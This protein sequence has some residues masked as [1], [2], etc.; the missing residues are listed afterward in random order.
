MLASFPNRGW[1]SVEGKARTLGLK[2]PPKPPISKTLFRAGDIGFSAG[3]TIAD[4]CIME[5]LISSGTK[6][7][8]REGGG[9]RRLRWYS[10]PQVQVSMEDKESLDRLARMW[11]KSVSF[12]QRSSVGNDVWRVY[13]HGQKAYDLL[14]IMLPYL[15]GEKRRKA[16]YLLKKYRKKTSLPVTSPSEFHAF[17][18]MN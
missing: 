15:A 7:G 14:K 1:G 2:R 4:G 16:L 3:M 11:G 13:V 12:C 18:G 17:G 5:N 6:R 10:L 9:K 8:R